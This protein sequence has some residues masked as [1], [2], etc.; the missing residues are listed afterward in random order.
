MTY[1]ILA[2]HYLQHLHTAYFIL[3]VDMPPMYEN[4]RYQNYDAEG[5]MNNLLHRQL[6]MRMVRMKLLGDDTGYGRTERLACYSQDLMRCSCPTCS[7]MEDGM[8]I[9]RRWNEDGTR[10]SSGSL[11]QTIQTLSV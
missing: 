9:E 2:L 11:S 8:K 6:A 5:E 7:A 10:V 1:D 4:A 3:D